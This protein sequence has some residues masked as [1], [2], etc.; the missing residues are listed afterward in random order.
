MSD[1]DVLTGMCERAVAILEKPLVSRGMTVREAERELRVK[2]GSAVRAL[3]ALHRVNGSLCECGESWPCPSLRAVEP[4]VI[5][6]LIR[7]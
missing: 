3:L 7:A 6:V 1:D 2:A 5:S 4:L